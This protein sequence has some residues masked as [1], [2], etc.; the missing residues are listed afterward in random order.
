[1][2]YGKTDNPAIV[3]GVGLLILYETLAIYPFK[4]QTENPT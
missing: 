3:T 1:L 2:D 4:I